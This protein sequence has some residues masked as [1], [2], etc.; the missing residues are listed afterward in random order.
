M[1]LP[2]TSRFVWRGLDGA[3]LEGLFW[4]SQ[5]CPSCRCPYLW[6]WQVGVGAS[7]RGHRVR[8]CVA[9]EAVVSWVDAPPVLEAE[10]EAA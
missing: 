2:S 6:E 5:K 1:N 7:S 8:E 4:W 3:T 10:D 9:C